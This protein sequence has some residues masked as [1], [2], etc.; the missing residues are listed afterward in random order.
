[1]IKR[2]SLLFS[3]VFAT[4]GCGSDTDSASPITGD[5]G[6]GDSA[7]PRTDAGR[8]SDAHSQPD[9][10]TSG[11]D[12][13]ATGF[14]SHLKDTGTTGSLDYSDPALWI[15]N[16][17]S[18][19]DECQR[20]IDATELAKD[21]SQKVDKHVPATDPAFDCF[22]VYP[23]VNLTGPGNT[24]DL[25]NITPMLDPLLGQAA[26]FTRLCKVYA[27]LYRQQSL[28]SAPPAPDAGGNG[29]LGDAT[30]AQ[31][32]V[33]SAFKYYLD[34]WNKG[35]RFVLIGHSQ[36]TL[37]L[38]GVISK[39]IDGDATLRAKL[40]SALLIGA[41]DNTLYAPTGAKVGGTFQNIPF[42][43]TAGETGCIIAYNSYAKDSPPPA[44]STFGHAPSGNVNGCTNPSVLAGNTGRYL[45]SYLPTKVNTAIFA[46]DTPKGQLPSVTTPFVLYRDFFTGACVD[47]NG[48]SYLEVN[49]DPATDDQ[50]TVPPYRTSL[51]EGL[52]L[53]AHIYDFAFE[54]DDLITAVDKQAKAAP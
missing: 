2:S 29:L 27:P 1:M 31:G 26:R 19:G 39:F 33:E 22:Y 48:V 30:L 25:S 23:T 28:S 36:G 41:L 18:E 20:N 40:V 12:G 44:T 16:P 37:R 32:D 46:A 42:C 49:P 3:F 13:A 6:G 5:G 43:T 21:N 51:V 38:I 47:K 4:V 17:G 9:V 50:R 52:G 14:R 35:R 54:Q 45:G 34:N 7:S 10:H 24:T 11:G 15:C 8:Q 53:G